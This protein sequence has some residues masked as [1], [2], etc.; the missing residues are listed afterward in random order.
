MIKLVLTVDVHKN[1]PLTKGNVYEG[2]LTPND[3]LKEYPK[4]Y[5]VRCDDG[6]FR[7]VEGECFIPLREYNLDSLL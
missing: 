7:K 2:E 3:P 6:K 5:I 4:S 1:F